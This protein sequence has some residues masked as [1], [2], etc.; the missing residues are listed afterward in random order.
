MLLTDTIHHYKPFE[1]FAAHCHLRI[2]QHQGQHVVMV[3]EMADNPEISITSYWPELAYEIVDQY[4]LPLAHTIWLEHYPQAAYALG[5]TRGDTFDQLTLGTDLPEWRRL[6]VDVVEQLIGEAIPHTGSIDAGI[7][8]T[9][10]RT[11]E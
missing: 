2:Y 6:A 9:I 10:D 4:N 3:S 7:H 1:Q 11:V 5:G 8:D